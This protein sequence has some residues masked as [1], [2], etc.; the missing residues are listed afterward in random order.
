MTSTLV[1]NGPL[2]LRD[3]TGPYASAVSS[4]IATYITHLTAQP[5]HT[6]VLNLLA[7]GVD[8]RVLSSIAGDPSALIVATTTPAWFDKLPPAAQSYFKSVGAAEASISESIVSSLSSMSEAA[9]KATG[10]PTFRPVASVGRKEREVGISFGSGSVRYG[11][12][13][14]VS[15]VFLLVL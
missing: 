11:A 1:A 8:P 14:F 13:C 10:A 12:L 6:S 2:E 7:T 15:L 5:Q 4:G 9:G 3:V